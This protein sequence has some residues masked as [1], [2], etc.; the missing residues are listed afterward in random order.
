[1][2]WPDWSPSRAVCSA[3]VVSR[4]CPGPPAR[5]R[6]SSEPLPG[7][8]GWPTPLLTM[9]S[10]HRM[11][12]FHRLPSVPGRVRELLPEPFSELPTGAQDIPGAGLFARVVVS[13]S[14]PGCLLMGLDRLDWPSPATA[15]PSHRE[16]ERHLP[17][18]CPVAPDPDW[19]R[20]SGDSR[21]SLVALTVMMTSERM[22]I[23]GMTVGDASEL[24]QFRAG[25]DQLKLRRLC[26]NG[27][28]RLTTRSA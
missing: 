20:E 14:G 25:R 28:E 21:M 11:L 6:P 27:V 7:R 23:G 10:V 2:H 13:Q 4:V 5:V 9:G 16:A 12:C 22:W 1:V 8:R 24:S 15:G 18:L 26:R 19:C 3:S 17:C